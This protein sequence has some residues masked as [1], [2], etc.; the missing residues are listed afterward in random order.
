MFND[1]KRNDLMKQSLLILLGAQL[2]PQLEPHP[3]LG[4][5]DDEVIEQFEK[6]ITARTQQLGAVPGTRQ[7]FM[8][9]EISFS[10]D[11]QVVCG[12][13]TLWHALAVETFGAVRDAVFPPLTEQAGQTS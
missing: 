1:A 11:P 10:S 3:E 5:W 9:A 12:N 13:G 4:L 7:A 2:V 6:L 8:K